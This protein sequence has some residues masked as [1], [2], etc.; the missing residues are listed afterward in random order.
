MVLHGV[1]ER[2]LGL[3][4]YSD[5]DLLDHYFFS[6]IIE[7]KDFAVIPKWLLALVPQ[8]IHLIDGPQPQATPRN[9]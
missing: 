9:I 7:H 8:I 6:K 5:L 4:K 3:L 2:V 1:F